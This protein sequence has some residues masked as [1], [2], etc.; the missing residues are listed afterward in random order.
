[1]TTNNS[2]YT[3]TKLKV[4]RLGISISDEMNDNLSLHTSEYLVVG[5]HTTNTGSGSVSTI[6]LIVDNDGFAVNSTIDNRRN[7]TNNYAAQIYGNTHIDG[8][9]IINGT[10]RATDTEI[11]SGSGGG[12]SG[13]GYTHWKYAGETSIYHDGTTTL[14]QVADA[15]SNT[16]TLNISENANYSITAAHFAMQ[17]RNNSL[18]RMSILGSSSNSPIIF[19]TEHNT[20]IEFHVGRTQEYFDSIYKI[21]PTQPHLPATYR[22]TPNYTDS[23]NAPHFNIDINGN[24]GIKTSLNTPIN[25]TVNRVD[26]ENPKRIILT[27]MFETSSLHIEGN[28]YSTNIL[29]HDYE[30]GRH[31]H[32]DQIYLRRSDIE[33]VDIGTM[34]LDNFTR[35]DFTFSGDL[36][37]RKDLTVDNDVFV[38]NDV[39]VGN[40]ITTDVIHVN[41]NASFSNNIYVQDNI[42][43]KSGIYTQVTDELD[44]NGQP[45]WERIQF[46]SS[47]FTTPTLS[48]IYYIGTG[49]ATPGR[50]GIGASPTK[51]EVNHQAVIVKRDSSIFELELTDKTVFGLKKTAFIGHPRVSD[52]FIADGSLVFLTPNPIDGDYSYN[53]NLDQN[54]YFYPGGGV[55]NQLSEFIIEN[56]NKPTLGIFTNNRVGI[57]TF[58]PTHELSVVGDLA[59][60]GS[61]YI[62]RS[63]IDGFSKMGLWAAETYQALIS[64]SNTTYEG[65]SYI[66]SSAP[67]V[68]I[69]VFPSENHGLKVLGGILSVDGFYAGENH[70]L[71]QFYYSSNMFNKPIPDYEFVYLNGQLGIGV[72]HPSATMHLSDNI[73]ATKL[74]LSQGITSDSTIIHFNGTSTDYSW[75]LDELHKTFELHYGDISSISDQSI[76]KPLIAHRTLDGTHQIIINSNLS[77]ANT[78]LQ[79]TALVVN[80]NID[81]QGDINVSGT[82]KVSGNGITITGSPAAAEYYNNIES[83]SMSENV[84]IGGKNIYMNTDTSLMSAVFIGWGDDVPSV[85][86]RAAVYIRNNNTTGNFVVDYRTNA[87]SCLTKYENASLSTMVIGVTQSAPLFIGRNTS[88]PYIVVTNAN[89]LETVGIG[90]QLPNGA[91]FHT[92]TASQTQPIAHF[93]RYTGTNDKADMVCD[94]T[95]E[96]QAGGLSYSW[97]IQGPNSVASQKLQFM[98]KDTVTPEREVICITKDGCVGIGNSFPTFAIDIS[99]SDGDRGSIRMKHSNSATAKPQLLFQSGPEDFGGDPYTDYRIYAH[100]NTF[101]IDSSL[102][103][104]QVADA[105]NVLLNF[106]ENNNLGI[107]Q[108]ADD[109]YTVTVGGTLNVTESIYIG[110]KVLLSASTDES[111][112]STSALNLYFNPEVSS[113]GGVSINGL[114]TTSNI[115]QVN[116]GL[117]GNVGVFNSIYDTSY[118]HFRNITEGGV[119]TNN[120]CRTGLS[121]NC[122]IQEFRSN[123]SNNEQYISD[124]SEGYIRASEIVYVNDHFVHKLNGS[125]ELTSDAPSVS[126]NTTSMIGSSNESMYVMTKN[127]GVGTTTPVSKLHIVN[128]HETSSC[129]INQQTAFHDILSI[130]NH[131]TKT[132]LVINA[133]GNVGI[134]TTLPEQNLHVLGDTTFIGSVGIGITV[135]TVPLHVVGESKFDGIVT[136]D[137]NINVS[138][139]GYITGN[140][141]I[142]GTVINDSDISV[143]TDI[144]TIEGALAKIKLLSGYTFS[145]RGLQQRETGV[146]AQEVQ[147]VLP[148]AVFDTSDG[149]LGV[150]YGNL[151]GLLIEGIKELSQQIETLRN[152]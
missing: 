42:Y 68:G 2:T 98:Y 75:H 51:D 58:K 49:I 84:Y 121:N 5:E 82:Y 87:N 6:G 147:N 103:A 122:F 13:S 127:L 22:S 139:N 65:I 71:A 128:S 72:I 119:N 31:K 61:Y 26:P 69:N 131:E 89:G 41:S 134:G 118:I 117:N 126:F 78:L 12:G 15:T 35:S 143:N 91:R 73:N 93:T 110:G 144:Q 66:N 105:T 81:V 24:V 86:D 1:M 16:Y 77:Y 47:F 148:E 125:F 76:I 92:Y 53:N 52:D 88:T 142:Q 90:T 137:S 151:V 136:V 11:V 33:G 99:T 149:L 67:H 150:A 7:N 62:K 111:V 10:I 20:P 95:L 48:N 17:N 101:T 43:F 114:I 104:S 80:G 56:D 45:K 146:I 108:L 83:S 34:I 64:S 107:R 97:K 46:D 29:M 44:E 50:I 106:N 85:E 18:F 37:L 113:H 9:L 25:F 133:S 130:V 116:S 27:D 100:N 4:G 145:K 32:L 152:M 140:L 129:I 74:Q 39:T 138:G 59:V 38:D 19:N 55:S 123:I 94:I 54:I 28:M 109:S 57:N 21:P 132:T 115:F 96:K 23:S 70:K 30:T 141:E 36:I 135:P 3:P 40:R 14:G 60:D 79:N 120:I 102:T 63:N 124:S 112:I 8:D